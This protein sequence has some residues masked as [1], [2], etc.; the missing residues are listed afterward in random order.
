M[1]GM[2][3][4]PPLERR[5]DQDRSRVRLRGGERPG[6]NLQNGSEDA[7]LRVRVDEHRR[8]RDL[9]ERAVAVP[10]VEVARRVP[11]ELLR[12]DDRDTR[13][14][15]A[16]AELAALRREGE[17]LRRRL[18]RDRDRDRWALEEGIAA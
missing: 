17:D 8:R 2:V 10:I 15:E 9:L 12:E 13:R 4:S 18:G 3:A 6:Q 7:R 16:E 5:V 11:C 1:E 14:K